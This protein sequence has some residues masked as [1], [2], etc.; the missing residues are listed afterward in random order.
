MRSPLSEALRR[1]ARRALPEGATLRRDRGDA[2]FVTDAPVRAGGGNW[3]SGLAEAGFIVRADGHLAHLTPGPDWITRLEA[4]WPEPPDSL[5]A[6]LIRYRGLSPDGAVLSLIA[7][8]LR[9]LDGGQEGPAYDRLLRQRAALCLRAP[10][11]YSPGGLYA[12]AL[13]D[14]LIERERCT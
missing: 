14:H 13:I 2:L 8:G 9:A 12:C 7:M 4:D 6:T 10:D 3:A 11:R 1:A 5:S